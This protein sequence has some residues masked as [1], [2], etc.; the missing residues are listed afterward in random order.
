MSELDLTSFTM[1]GLITGIVMLVTGLSY[2]RY[3]KKNNSI[4]KH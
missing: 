1:W 3:L 4:S 2:R